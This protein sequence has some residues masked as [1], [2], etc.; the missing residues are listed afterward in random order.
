M[1]NSCSVNFLRMLSYCS[2]RNCTTKL[3]IE[4]HGAIRYWLDMLITSLLGRIK[5]LFYLIRQTSTH[6]LYLKNYWKTTQKGEAIGKK[7]KTSSSRIQG[8]PILFL[9]VFCLVKKCRTVL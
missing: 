2:R 3:M 5:L 4:K 7:A 9:F 8:K 6:M 1:M